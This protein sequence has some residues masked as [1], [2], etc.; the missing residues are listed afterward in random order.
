MYMNKLL[1]PFHGTLSII[2][3]LITE[4]SDDESDCTA[5]TSAVTCTDSLAWPSGS[6]MST[7]SVSLTLSRT[8]SRTVV[9]KPA[10]LTVTE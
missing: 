10:A 5:V 8:P 1:W 7:F 4:P 9:L 3:L 6:S 2:A